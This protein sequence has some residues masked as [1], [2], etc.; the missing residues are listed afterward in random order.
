[1]DGEIEQE[2]RVLPGSAYLFSG[3]EL[4]VI[5]TGN[6]AALQVY[7]NQ[8]DQG[9]LGQFGE[10]IERAY[11]PSGPVQPTAMPTPLPTSTS[12]PEATPTP[13]PTPTSLP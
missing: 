5:Q 2:G 1:V 9:I 8:Q 3:N 7:F 11:S 12:P 4:V 6:A 10:V 13:T